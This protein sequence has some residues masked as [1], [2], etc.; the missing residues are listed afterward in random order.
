LIGAVLGAAGIETAEDFVEE[1][2]AGITIPS[3]IVDAVDD[4]VGN[5]TIGVVAVTIAVT[6]WLRR[7]VHEAGDALSPD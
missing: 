1:V 2:Q 3:G 7:L 4:R 6:S 5:T